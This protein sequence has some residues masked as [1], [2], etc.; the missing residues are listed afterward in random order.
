MWVKAGL[1]RD[2]NN[3][4]M[5]TDISPGP[6]VTDGQLVH[7][8]DLNALVSES[9]ILPTA[10]S[11]RTLK[12]E[13]SLGDEFLINDSGTLK[14]TTGQQIVKI[15]VLPAG[16]MMDFAGT[17]EPLG[18]VFCYGQELSRTTYAALYEA[19]GDAYGAGDGTSTFN[20]P[21][22]RGR[23]TA[24]DDNMG[25]TA[26]NRITNAISGFDAMI[27]GAAGGS[28]SHTLV[29]AETPVTVPAHNHTVPDHAH[30]CDGVDH[31]HYMQNHAHALPM[32]DS[33]AYSTPRYGLLFDGWRVRVPLLHDS[34]NYYSGGSNVGYTAA[35]DRG[36]AFW[37]RGSGVLTSDTEPAI[38][39]GGT[40]HRNVQPTLITNKIIKT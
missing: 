5:G 9:T 17:A 11:A 15:A 24:G 35:C 16:C 21:D 1:H 36:M 22:C 33:D 34:L 28:E 30:Y 25:G 8:A 26:A 31:L 6:T 39:T 23:V 27:L 7:D 2:N 40:A 20:V 29:A 38:A 18:W 19:I 3:N 4:Y 37:S 14:K 13:L 32:T 10:I 12:P